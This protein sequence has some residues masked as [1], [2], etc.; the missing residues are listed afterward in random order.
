MVYLHKD[1]PL[2]VKEKLEAEKE[3]AR[4]TCRA[5]GSDG[6]CVK[7]RQPGPQETLIDAEVVKT[8][9]DAGTQLL[10]IAKV[11]KEKEGISLSAAIEKACKMNPSLYEEYS[12]RVL[13]GE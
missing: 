7:A 13:R 12:N 8:N 6:V 11:L 10:S 4:R 1:M 9:P 2:W 3:N 5:D